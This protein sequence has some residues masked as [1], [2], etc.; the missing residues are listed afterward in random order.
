MINPD[1]WP[2]KS[3]GGAGAEKECLA[4]VRFSQSG[5]EQQKTRVWM[6][7]EEGLFVVGIVDWMKPGGLAFHDTYLHAVST[8][9]LSIQAGFGWPS[10]Y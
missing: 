8:H 5:V 7:G 1:A 9:L 4:C 2:V 10:G 3:G 6:I